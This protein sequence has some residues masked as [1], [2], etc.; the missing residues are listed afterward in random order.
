MFCQSCGERLPDGARFCPQCGQNCSMQAGSSSN[1]S[2]SFDDELSPIDT[3]HKAMAQEET[4]SSASAP[5]KRKPTATICD[6]APTIGSAEWRYRHENGSNNG[7]AEYFD[8]TLFTIS[9]IPHGDTLDMPL[10]SNNGMIIPGPV[11]QFHIGQ[12]NRQ[13]FYLNKDYQLIS[14]DLHGKNAVLIAGGNGDRVIDFVLNGDQLFLI[15]QAK[16]KERSIFQI[17]QSLDSHI[18]LKKGYNLRG[19]AADHNYLYY[20]D[21]TAL[22][23]RDL[24]S[25]AEK[26]ILKR[27]G[28]NTFQLYNGYLILTISDNIYS[29]HDKD[30]YILL[31]DPVRMLQRVV[32]QV[33][34]K[35]VNC[36]WDHVFYTDAKN[37]Y[38]WAIPL[39]GG[40]AHLLRNK[41]S[42]NLNAS[43]GQ[44]FFVDCASIQISSINL[45]NGT[46]TALGSDKIP[47]AEAEAFQ[48]SLLNQG[49]EHYKDYT[50]NQALLEGVTLLQEYNSKSELFDYVVFLTLPQLNKNREDVPALLK[51][52][53]YQ[54]K[55]G[56]KP[57]VF[58]DSTLSHKRGK[59]FIVATDGI[60]TD[61][62]FFPY[63][64]TFDC[65]REGGPQNIRLRTYEKV[66]FGKE[67]RTLDISCPMFKNGLEDLTELIYTVYAFS[68]FRMPSISDGYVLPLPKDLSRDK[69]PEYIN[70]PKKK[71]AEDAKASTETDKTSGIHKNEET[72]AHPKSVSG[73][74]EDHGN[75]EEIK[76]A[77]EKEFFA[78]MEQL[79]RSKPFK[80]V[81]FYNF[82]KVLLEFAFSLSVWLFLLGGVAVQNIFTRHIESSIVLTITGIILIVFGIIAIIL[83][84]FIFNGIC[85]SLKE[86]ISGPEGKAIQEKYA[87]FGISIGASYTPVGIRGTRNAVAV[88]LCGILASA[89]LFLLCDVML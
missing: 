34:A 79:W 70:P 65:E 2:F 78:E 5:Q 31:I 27:T 32:A 4:A 48:F 20:I 22:T 52:A 47:E 1:V 41:A 8:D 12:K 68:F 81:F 53:G 9:F 73:G 71:T 38:I 23:Q 29:N 63:D 77:K 69:R 55:S 87:Q 45:R 37:E 75:A 46:E 14:C 7:L 25:G 42:D 85:D 18:V 26:V 74:T 15:L 61:K 86:K 54:Q 64:Y 62:T 16:D 58:V 80:D 83:T 84:G 43:C 24:K 13:I 35:N 88:V 19:L 57:I 33:A 67:K 6:D 66:R 21:G 51:A 50:L 44:L 76:A 56:S 49:A 82:I 11:G 36:Y 28:I 89:F 10:M 17:S 30:N 40:S 72:M 3:P 60:Y 59:G 39:T